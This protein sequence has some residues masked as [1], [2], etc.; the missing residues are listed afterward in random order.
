MPEPNALDVMFDIGLDG[1][2]THHLLRFQ[3]A[4]P[5][6]IANVSIKTTNNFNL[7]FDWSCPSRSPARIAA[8]VCG[9]AT[10]F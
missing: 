9:Y 4:G 8:S 5:F 3:A 10:T 6:E 1:A 7:L 2:I